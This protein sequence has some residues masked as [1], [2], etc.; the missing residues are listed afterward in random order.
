MGHCERLVF[1][2]QQSELSPVIALFFVCRPSAVGWMILAGTVVAFTAP[3][4]PVV[5]NAI[6]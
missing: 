3:V 4:A 2:S 5:V 6:Y 1:I